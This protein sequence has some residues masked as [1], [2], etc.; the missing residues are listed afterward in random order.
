LCTLCF[1]CTLCSSCT[2]L[3][4]HHVLCAHYILCVQYWH[5]YGWLLINSSLC[6]CVC[7][8]AQTTLLTG[9]THTP[10]SNVVRACRGMLCTQHPSHCTKNTAQEECCAHNTHNIAQRALFKSN[11]VQTTHMTFNSNIVQTNRMFLYKNDLV[12]LFL[13]ATNVQ[14]TCVENRNIRVC[15]NV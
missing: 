6:A 4:A 7:T 3:F 2:V 10:V 9:H 13:F 8:H 14:K 1:L 12:H 11:A 15:K 5:V